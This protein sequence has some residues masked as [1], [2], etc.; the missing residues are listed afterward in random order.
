MR[1]NAAPG[2]SR[3]DLIAF[4]KTAAALWRKLYP[5]VEFRG[6]YSRKW[7]I[8]PLPNYIVFW[9]YESPRLLARV[10]EETGK[11][12]ELEELIA[13]SHSLLVDVENSVMDLLLE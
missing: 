3:E 6:L 11:E 1:F 2:A 7:R 13:R 9:E 12:P 10:W 5:G 4:F 8:G